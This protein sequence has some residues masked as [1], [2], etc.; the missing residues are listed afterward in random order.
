MAH[1]GAPPRGVPPHDA[2]LHG[3]PLHGAPPHASQALQD[4]IPLIDDGPLA[5]APNHATHHH[6][7]APARRLCY[8]QLIHLDADHHLVAAALLYYHLLTH[9]F[10][11]C[12]QPAV[13]ANHPCA[14]R[15]RAAL[16]VALAR[17]LGLALAVAPDKS[18]THLRKR[19]RACSS[20]QA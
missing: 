19:Q 3:V 17:G 10:F 9:Q 1:H 4:V 7:V 16:V 5:V 20:S 18:R 15:R 12:H 6:R 13:L 8:H 2:P 11:L 14:H